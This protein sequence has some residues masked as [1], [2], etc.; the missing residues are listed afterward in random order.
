[1]DVLDQRMTDFRSEMHAEFSAL[2]AENQSEFRAMR[3]EHRADFRL[4]MGLILTATGATLAVMA[5]G[6]HWLP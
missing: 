6:F 1:M 3:A 2:R 5:H 4:L